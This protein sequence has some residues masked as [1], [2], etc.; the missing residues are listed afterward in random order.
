MTQR[1]PLELLHGVR[2][3][4]WGLRCIALHPASRACAAL[5]QLIIVA[6]EKRRRPAGEEDREA[7]V[8][9]TRLVEWPLPV[10]ARGASVLRGLRD[11]VRGWIA[12]AQAKTLLPPSSSSTHYRR[13]YNIC[14]WQRR[15][16]LFLLAPVL[17]AFGD[18]LSCEAL[19]DML[20]ALSQHILGSLGN[21][22]HLLR[23]DVLMTYPRLPF[24]RQLQLMESLRTGYALEKCGTPPPPE[25]YLGEYVRHVPP[26]FGA[27]TLSA[28]QYAELRRAFELQKQTGIRR[29]LSCTP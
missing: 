1:D 4:P 17:D 9:L 28:A 5:R 15:H 2:P 21:V 29:L 12:A 22:P 13:L 14:L 25:L 3:S 26:R 19:N 6:E 23:G 7:A 16:P 24:P 11:V 27:D 10:L 20:E 8:L 18:Q